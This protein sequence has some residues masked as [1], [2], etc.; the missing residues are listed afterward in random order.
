MAFSDEARIG[1]DRHAKGAFSITPDDAANLP[2]PARALY[3]GTLGNVKVDMND[4]TTV[5]WKTLA[6]GVIHPIGC[7]K[8]YSTGTTAVDIIGVKE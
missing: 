1:V 7:I 8:V 6:A 3:V 5:T 2:F 4:G